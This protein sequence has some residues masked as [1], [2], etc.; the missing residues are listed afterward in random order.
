MLEV[1]IDEYNNT[2]SKGRDMN[3]K[4]PNQIY[5]ESLETVRRVNDEN[6]LN[7]LCGI[8]EERTV[9]KN[10]IRI[11]NNYFYDEILI[12]YY[13]K[14]VIASYVP[15][16]IDKII[17]FDKDMK[18]IGEATA[19]IV[20]AYR[21]TTEEDYKRAQRE[22]RAVREHNKQYESKIEVDIHSII[23]TNQFKEKQYTEQASHGTINQIVP[24]IQNNSHKLKGITGTETRNREHEEFIDILSN[25]YATL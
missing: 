2:E 5:A 25:Y 22:K 18:I 1:Y 19:K 21:N 13:N 14:K 15:E 24:V 4:T 6:M 11:L 16:N 23:A 10:G 20:T 7:I 3:G 9:G 17:V 12:P 8:F